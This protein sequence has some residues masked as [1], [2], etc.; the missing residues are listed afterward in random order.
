LDFV[1]DTAGIA[2]IQGVID[3]AD[4][5]GFLVGCGPEL[6]PEI[7][8]AN[9]PMIGLVGNDHT[10]DLGAPDSHPKLVVDYTPGGGEGEGEGEGEVD[11]SFQEG[12][13]PDASY[14]HDMAMLVGDTGSG[15]GAG[16][17]DFFKIGARWTQATQWSWAIIRYD[18]SAIPAGATINSATFV[19]EAIDAD[20]MDTSIQ[21]QDE[22][23][24]HDTQTMHLYKMLPANA[25]WIEGTGAS[26]GGNGLGEVAFEVMQEDVACWPVSDC[27]WANLYPEGWGYQPAGQPVWNASGVISDLTANMTYS[28]LRSGNFENT[29]EFDFNATGLA[30]LQDVVDGAADDAGFLLAP[31]DETIGD[32][33][34]EYIVFGVVTDDYAADPTKRPRLDVNYSPP[35]PTNV[36]PDPEMPV[37]GALGL[38]LLAAATAI[39]G[40]CAR[41]K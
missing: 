20:A 31:P 4:D 32:G 19:L 10:G 1:F 7:D 6:V 8:G 13:S 39:A 27:T 24:W 22:T 21:T 33:P 2:Y 17:I 30:Y 35:I 40:I 18:L 36:A 11:I 29:L 14:E 3:G 5:A 12:V 37:A 28:S 23:L 15:W 41:K 26:E 16:A 38:G 34:D 9:R 25:G